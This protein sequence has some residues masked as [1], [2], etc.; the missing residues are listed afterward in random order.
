[1][2]SASPAPSRWPPSASTASAQTGARDARRSR[3]VPLGDRPADR[4]LAAHRLLAQAAD[5]GEELPGA[6]GGVGADQDRGAVPVRVGDLGQ[7]RVEHGDVVGG[8]VRSGV[9]RAAAAAARNSPVLSRKPASGDSRT[10]CL[11]V[12]ARLLLLA[13]THHDRGVQVDHQP[14]QHPPGRASP[15]GTPRPVS[16][17]AAPTPPPG[18]RPEPRAT[19][20]SA[21]SSSRSSSRQ[22]VESDATGPNNSA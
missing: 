13:V 16:R 3:R 2:I 20:P 8:G 19:A 7:R 10:C 12:G 1:M 9:A 5:V 14:G 4:E 15:A 18:P 6:A 17:R 21:R 22:H 11:N